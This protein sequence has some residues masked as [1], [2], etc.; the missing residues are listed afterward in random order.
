MTGV[1]DFSISSI[2]DHEFFVY[3]YTEMLAIIE[4]LCSPSVFVFVGF[5]F[6]LFASF[7]SP[8]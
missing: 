4:Q 2:S 7:L 5:G 6:H 8:Y 1:S 3:M